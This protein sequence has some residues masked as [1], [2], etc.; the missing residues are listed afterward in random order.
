[1]SLHLAAYDISRD[2]SRRHVAKTLLRYGRR[3]QESV[4]EIDLEPADVDELKREI[5]PWLAT[6]DLFDVY[7]VDTRRP[8]SRVRWQMEPYREPVLLM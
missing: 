7:P 4:F 5:G 3:I 2:T 1:M 6:T 8:A